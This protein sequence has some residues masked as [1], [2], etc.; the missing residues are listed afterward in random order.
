AIT[1]PITASI[2][3]SDCPLGREAAS[4]CDEGSSNTK[5]PISRDITLQASKASSPTRPQF[6]SLQYTQLTPCD[7]G[8]SSRA[9][10]QAPI[11][12][13]TT[14]VTAPSVSRP[15][16]TFLL[17]SRDSQSNWTAAI[18]PTIWDQATAVD[19][20]NV[21]IT[22]TTFLPDDWK[23]HG[24]HEVFRLDRKQAKKAEKERRREL[25]ELERQ[26]RKK[27]EKEK[28]AGKQN[29]KEKEK[30]KAKWKEKD[31]KGK[32]KEGT[33]RRYSMRSEPSRRVEE[34]CQCL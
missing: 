31:K 5:L 20:M 33:F 12:P 21:S 18:F 6:G 30:E 2:T 7:I 28:K 24:I 27:K 32:R 1:R 9:S 19:G 8:T 16:D 15:C 11:Q 34:V 25:E 3:N 13:I 4:G 17:G 29:K 10:T 26:T 14:I 22:N 23:D